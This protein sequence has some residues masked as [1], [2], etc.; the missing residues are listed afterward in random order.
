MA[1]LVDRLPPQDARVDNSAE[2]ADLPYNH[3]HLDSAGLLT[4]PDHFTESPTYWPYLTT[5]QSY[6]PINCTR[7]FYR[8]TGLRTILDHSSDFFGLIPILDHST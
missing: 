7:P 5:L 4:I 3:S 1:T 6:R 2:S 8:V